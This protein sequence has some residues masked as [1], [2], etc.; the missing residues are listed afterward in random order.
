MAGKKPS[1]LIVDDEVVVCSLLRKEL[2]E[3]GYICSTALDGHNALTKL[4][5]QD[6]DVILLDIKLPGLS[7]MEVLSTI[8][9]ARYNTAAIMITGVR[10]V[11]TA[12]EAMKLGAADYIVKPF[13]PDEVNTSI[14]TVLDTQKQLPEKSDY[15]TPLCR[16]SETEDR[17]AVGESHRQMDAIARG[18]EVRHD[19]IFGHS[20]I[21][22]QET[23]DIARQLGIPEKVINRWVDARSALDSEMNRI[24]LSS[25]DKLERSP[26][27]QQVLGLLRPYQHI[28]KPDKSQN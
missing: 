18:V 7:G 13:S 10:S 2:S 17:S 26:L 22:A 20:K 9:S 25:L 19:L 6:F 15:Q 12:V 1:I 24:I 3:R 4:A 5:A 16:G 8:R 28:Q 27:V 21:I 23:V 11:D 14:Q